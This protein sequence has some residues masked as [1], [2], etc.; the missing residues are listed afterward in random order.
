[1]LIKARIL[2]DSV[3]PGLKWTRLHDGYSCLSSLEWREWGHRTESTERA[4]R[5]PGFGFLMLYTIWSPDFVFLVSLLSSSDL[6]LQIREG[7]GFNDTFPPL[8]FL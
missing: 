1:M 3:A 4:P 8:V 7:S 5:L 2:F 6:G